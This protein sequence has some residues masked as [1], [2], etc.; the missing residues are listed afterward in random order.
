MNSTR[1]INSEE[2]KYLYQFCKRKDIRYV[3]L[4]L[5]LVDHLAKRI[6]ELWS[7][8]YTLNFKDALHK[9][10]KSFGV[11]GMM[12]IAEEH[13]KIVQKRYWSFVKRE[14]AKWLSP[15]KV[16][17]TLLAS[18]IIYFSMHYWQAMSSFYWLLLY[19]FL[20]FSFTYSLWYS[21]KLYRSLHNDH[22]MYLNVSQYMG[23]AVYFIIIN[24]HIGL[25]SGNDWQIL[26]IHKIPQPWFTTL[27][28]V[29]VSLFLISNLK[30][31]GIAKKQVA[32]LQAQTSCF[33]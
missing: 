12:S 24:S 25:M 4:R 28:F 7:Q 8:D 1:K 2:L 30:L 16:L 20:I 26:G 33:I 27:I 21:K 14:F 18:A 19:A 5:E 32:D 13:E 9:V 6:E 17:G 10:H 22:S 3:E 29:L 11:F 23:W 31:L 15:P